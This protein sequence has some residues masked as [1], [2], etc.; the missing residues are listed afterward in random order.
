MCFA[1]PEKLVVL[2][3]LPTGVMSGLDRFI[4][5][6]P[7]H[8]ATFVQDFPTSCIPIERGRLQAPLDLYMWSTV[9]KLSGGLANTAQAAQR[10]STFLN[11]RVIGWRSGLAACSFLPRTGSPSVGVRNQK[12]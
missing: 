5:A 9:A 12:C 1:E 7:D 10:S 2:H 3:D 11:P 8:G 6:A 4:G